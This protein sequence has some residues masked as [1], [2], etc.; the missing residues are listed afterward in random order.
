MP[1]FTDGSAAIISDDS[2]VPLLV[3]T[4]YGVTTERLAREAMGWLQTFAVRMHERGE[5]FVSVIDARA[6]GR[7]PASVR[8]LV[9]TLTDELRNAAPGTELASLFVADNVL[10]RGALT[11]IN[12][13]QSL[14]MEAHHRV[15][16]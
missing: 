12:L 13:G 4:S 14:V 5:R 3:A 15:V 1:R 6:A 10:I 2:N 7:P 16:V 9:S 11:A 8:A